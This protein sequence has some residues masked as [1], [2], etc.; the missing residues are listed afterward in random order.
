MTTFTD[1]QQPTREIIRS[2]ARIDECF[3]AF[4]GTSGRARFSPLD[5]LDNRLNY[6]LSRPVVEEARIGVAN[7]S[8]DALTMKQLCDLIPVTRMQ[9]QDPAM[10]RDSLRDKLYELLIRIDHCTPDQLGKRT[11]TIAPLTQLSLLQL[12]QLVVF[13][14]TECLERLLIEKMNA[15]SGE[16]P[17]SS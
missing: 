7:I 5:H 15:D 16:T 6:L 2:F 1:S 17:V 13:M 3:D 8:F 14:T 9:S 10:L 11:I 4:D 12:S